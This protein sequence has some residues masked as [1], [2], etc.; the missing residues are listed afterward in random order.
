[1]CFHRFQLE[2]VK[3]SFSFSSLLSLTKLSR[4]CVR[5]GSLLMTQ[6]L[7]QCPG[8]CCGYVSRSWDRAGVTGRSSSRL[9]RGVTVFGLCPGCGQDHLQPRPVCWKEH[10]EFHFPD[11]TALME[12]VSLLLYCVLRGLSGFSGL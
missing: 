7:N 9:G 10:N 2:A 8:T 6:S 5:V 11:A 3:L 1:M 12:L 4:P